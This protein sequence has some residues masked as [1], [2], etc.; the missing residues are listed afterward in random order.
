[1]K[2]E[3]DIPQPALL[4]RGN[5]QRLW[6]SLMSMARIGATPG[7]GSSRLALSAEDSAGRYQFIAACQAIGMSVTSDAMGNLFCRF[8][9][10][11]PELLPV[12]MGSHLD[13][14]PK[15]GRFDGVYGVL[16]ALEVVTTLHQLQLTPRRSIEIIVWT[17]EEGARFTPAMMGSAVFTGKMSLEEALSRRDRDNILVSNALQQQG[18]CGDAPAGRPFDAYFEA[19]IEQGPVLEEES[20][21]IGI[22]TGGQ[23]IRWLDIT[24]CGQAAHAGTTPMK[25][26]RDAMFAASEMISALEHQA[27]LFA[28]Q[29]LMTVGEL[30]IAA[31]SRNTIAGNLRFTLDIRH[32]D[33]VIL[34]TFDQQCREVMQR[35]ADQRHIEITISEHWVSPAVPFDDQCVQL[36]EQLTLQLGY[37]GRRMISGAG[38][39]AINI[40]GHCP[41]AMIFIPCAGG[42]S[43]NESESITPEDAEYGLN[44]LLNSVWQRADR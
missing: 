15:G 4:L 3:S 32:P 24:V 20:L 21:G 13:T 43:H 37:P 39:D 9:G 29:G 14:Q 26:R 36:V 1:M 38:H 33:D 8:Q 40:A 25:N 6:D 17:N 42:I 41:T 7:G 23:A 2:I 34:Q 18:W 30:H 16:A 12:T 22:V 27:D 19:H 35:I 11:E 10:R 28:P 5:G 44:V 31:A